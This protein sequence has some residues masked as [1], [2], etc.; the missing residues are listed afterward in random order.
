MPIRRGLGIRTAFNI[1]GPMS[2]PAGAQA[3]VLGVYSPHLVPVVAHTLAA[4]STRHA[5]VV[6]GSGM[7]EFCLHGPSVYAEVKGDRVTFATLHPSDVGLPECPVE[8]LAG[9][10]AAHNANIL[11]SI[12]AGDHG[13]RRDVI[14]LNAA[15]VLVTASLATTLRAGIA[16]AQRTLDS[17]AVSTLISKLST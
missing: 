2:N 12:F 4:L 7:D 13:P 9:G 5:F 3:Q 6:H 10:D 1:L 16:L 11:R 8:A 14:V 17:G 15:A